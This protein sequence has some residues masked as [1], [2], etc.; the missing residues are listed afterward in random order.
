MKPAHL[1]GGKHRALVRQICFGCVLFCL[2]SIAPFP[3]PAA[4]EFSPQAVAGAQ[5]F[6]ATLR[7][8]AQYEEL[9][10]LIHRWGSN[11]DD[12]EELEFDARF[13]PELEARQR[14][15]ALAAGARQTL[16][17]IERRIKELGVKRLDESNWRSLHQWA[18]NKLN[19]AIPA[20]DLAFKVNLPTVEGHLARCDWE[21]AE[22]LLAPLKRA[23]DIWNV[24]ERT[25][26][27]ARFERALERFRSLSGRAV[28]LRPD[29]GEAKAAYQRG[30][31]AE[32]NGDPKKALANYRESKEHL[33]R[34]RGDVESSGCTKDQ[35][36]LKDLSDKIESGLKRLAGLEPRGC[37][38]VC[39]PFQSCER[40]PV[41]EWKIESKDG[42]Q[43]LCTGPTP[44][45]NN[46]ISRYDCD[47]TERVCQT[48]ENCQMI[49]D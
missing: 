8:A 26:T 32:R 14:Y 31:R 47:R 6:F 18:D 9:R 27:K 49:C 17:R 25:K 1:E 24:A 12:V 21:L 33:K 3:V 30:A 40:Q 43:G 39:E 22:P 11:L 41:C 15:G 48:V 34:I 42:R 28:R 7:Y 29:W 4:D 46:C 37:R 36:H 35:A 44:D 16:R 38:E 45:P 20:L 19:K 10:F 13:H 5:N 2:C 23:N